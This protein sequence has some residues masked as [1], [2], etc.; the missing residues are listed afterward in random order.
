MHI[1][2]DVEASSL[3]LTAANS[4]L[5]N[6]TAN[7]MDMLQGIIILF[8]LLTLVF[9]FFTYIVFTYNQ[10]TLRMLLIMEK[11]LDTDL[12]LILKG[13][14]YKEA[15]KIYNIEQ[16]VIRHNQKQV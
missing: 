9:Y 1:E 8:G 11:F 10:S 13:I 15:L 4:S 16:E 7:L 6:I 12:K 5:H 3:N 2:Y 14:F